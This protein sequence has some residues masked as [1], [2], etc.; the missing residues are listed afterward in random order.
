MGQQPL[1]AALV[2]ARRRR[3]VT[4][5]FHEKNPAEKQNVPKSTVPLRITDP[6]DNEKNQSA[7][8]AFE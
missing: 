1:R 3:Q 6:A 7:D 5:L 4:Y 2:R 8:A